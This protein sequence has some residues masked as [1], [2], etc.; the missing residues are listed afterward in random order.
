MRLVEN[1]IKH[2]LTRP[3][4]KGSVC[5]LTR[6]E[7]GFYRIEV[8]DDGV[9]FVP[10][11]LQKENTGRHCFVQCLFFHVKNRKNCF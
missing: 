10:E 5:I 6:Q 3:G 8:V 4:K 1:V 9:G 11:E 7:E 2:G